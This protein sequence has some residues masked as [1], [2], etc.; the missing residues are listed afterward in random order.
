MSVTAV[1]L[2]AGDSSRLGKP[3]QL[4]EYRGR[5]LLRHAAEAACASHASEVIA[6]LGFNAPQMLA[7]LAG[8]RLRTSENL[9]WREGIASSIRRG[10]ASLRPE[11]EG[12]L[13]I[14]CDQP[15]LTAG[16][17]DAL[18][19]AFTRTPDRPVASGYGG[20]AGVPA[21]FPRALFGELF[22][23][24]GDRGA[25]RILRAHEAELVTLPWPDGVFDVDTPEDMSGRL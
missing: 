23:L 13:L 9:L 12:A 25:Q 20:A 7:E 18:I 17:L 22:L 5:S 4:L 2:A 24:T 1:I 6:V 11:S 3:K 16:H 8:L 19:D 21:L 15:G 14:V 10:V